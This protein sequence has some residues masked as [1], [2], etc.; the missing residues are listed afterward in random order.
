MELVNNKRAAFLSAALLYF[1]KLFA[2][3]KVFVIYREVSGFTNET[4]SLFAILFNQVL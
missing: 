2:E 3:S 4:E 1:E